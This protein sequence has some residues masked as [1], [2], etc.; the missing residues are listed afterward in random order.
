LKKKILKGVFTKK[1]VTGKQKQLKN[2]K[3]KNKRKKKNTPTK[4]LSA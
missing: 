1:N 3:V 2:V 4:I